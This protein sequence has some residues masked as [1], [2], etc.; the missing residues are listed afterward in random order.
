MPALAQSYT[1]AYDPIISTFSLANPL[2]LCWAIEMW[3]YACL[4]MATW[5]AAV[6][7]KRDR[8][9]KATAVL[10]VANGIISIIGGIVTSFNLGWVLTTPGVISYVAWNVLVLALSI[11]VIASLRRR[12]SQ[13]VRAG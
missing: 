8:L 7:F 10:I 5:L 4:G 3:G 6:V 9:E 11:L 2:S 1:P 12:Q 13:A